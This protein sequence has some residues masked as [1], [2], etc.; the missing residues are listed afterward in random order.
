MGTSWKDLQVTVSE[1]WKDLEEAVGDDLKTVRK[2]LLEAKEKGHSLCSYVE[3]LATL[4]P[5]FMR[6]LER[7]PN[8]IV[9][10]WGD[11]KAKFQDSTGFF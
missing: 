4:S 9:G 11:L 3:N 10:A 2:M 1:T 7:V 8:G 6:N 5:V